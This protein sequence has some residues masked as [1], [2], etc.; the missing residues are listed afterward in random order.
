MCMCVSERER[1]S[2]GANL[3]QVCAAVA[4]QERWR[5]KKMCRG[6]EKW[7]HRTVYLGAHDRK[8]QLKEKTNR[9]EG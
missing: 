4:G 7:V 3:K 6:L 8:G 1:E 9:V 5:R 2:T